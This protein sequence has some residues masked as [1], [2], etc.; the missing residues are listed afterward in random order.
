MHILPLNR[1]SEAFIHRMERILP[2]KLYLQLLFGAHMGYDIDFRR[3]T[4]FN[5]KLQWLK[6][7][8]RR[9]EYTRLVDKVE[10]KN[11]VADKI[12][13]EYVIPTYK[14]WNSPGEIDLADLPDQFVLKCNH[15]GG[16]NA[17]FIVGDK[18]KFDLPMARESLKKA[19]NIC[20]Y[21]KYREWPYKNVR[22]RIL[23]EK[24]L[25]VG[26]E[27]YKFF[28]YDGFVESVMV[29]YERQTGSAKFYFFDKDWNLKRYNIRG[30][31]APADFTKP[32]PKNLD[33]M[34]ELASKLSKGIP[35]VRVD[36]Y[37]IDGKIYFG[38]MTFFPASGLDEKL[39]PET[40]DWFGSLIQLPENN[41][42]STYKRL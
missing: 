6:L 3:V 27:D 26:V 36:L 39:L 19:M 10:V 8:N 1:I 38:E 5:E 17:V 24:L 18:S 4:T 14:V 2:D 13:A 33:K 35:F 41:N 40:D 32:R 11:W 25:G 23:A 30:K 34:F 20:L 29:A 28:C 9:P 12:G 22:H 37:N 42:A 7:Y 16:N 31:E 15:T 21:R